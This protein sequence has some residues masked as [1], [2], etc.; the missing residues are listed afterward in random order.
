MEEELGNRILVC[1]FY[2]VLGIGM[3]WAFILVDPYVFGKAWA[4]PMILLLH[5]VFPIVGGTMIIVG[6]IYLAMFTIVP[7]WENGIIKRERT[8]ESNKN[9]PSCGKSV[10]YV[11]GEGYWCSRCQIFFR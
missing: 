3:I 1:I 11:L 7:R 10:T 9:C 8:H 2:L 6:I 5:W 4:P